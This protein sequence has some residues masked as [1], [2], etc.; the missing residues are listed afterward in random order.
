MAFAVAGA[1]LNTTAAIESGAPWDSTVATSLC[2]L[3]VGFDV[4]AALGGATTGVGRV[5]SGALAGGLTAAVMTPIT[6][7]SLGSNIFLG[8][9]YGAL[10]SAIAEG[11]R[12]TNPVDQATQMQQQGD[13]ETVEAMQGKPKAGGRPGDDDPVFC[14]RSGSP[15]CGKAGPSDQFDRLVLTRAEIVRS[16]TLQEDAEYGIGYKQ[17]AGG[18]VVASADS[19]GNELQTSGQ[20]G[21]VTIRVSYSRNGESYAGALHGHTTGAFSEYFSGKDINYAPPGS[22]DYLVTPKGAV[23]RFDQATYEIRVI[24]PAQTP[25]LP[26]VPFSR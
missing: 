8:A 16:A 3:A 5:L 9:S 1:V 17:T 25:P 7:G 26:M 2:G 13:Q 14:G 18:T 12:Y 23:L 21:D 20:N 4:G 10:A 15:A 6:G 22:R 19:A 24:Q 11:F